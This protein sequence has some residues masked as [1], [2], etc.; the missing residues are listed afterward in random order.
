MAQSDPL[1]M[2]RVISP[3]P[4]TAWH[5]LT[6][7]HYTTSHL[8]PRRSFFELHKGCF[9]PAVPA[10]TGPEP[11]TG[12][13]L[14]HDWG[15][16]RAWQKLDTGN[17]D[18][19]RSQLTVGPFASVVAVSATILTL[20]TRLA[21]QRSLRHPAIHEVNGRGVAFSTPLSEMVLADGPW[22]ATW[23]HARWFY[24]V[25]DTGTVRSSPIAIYYEF[26]FD[27]VGG[28]ATN[29]R[30]IPTGSP[31]LTGFGFDLTVSGGVVAAALSAEFTNGA[32]PAT[33]EPG[34]WQTARV[35]IPDISG[36][37]L[38]PANDAAIAAF[39]VGQQV[40]TGP[41]G[42]DV[43]AAFT[44]FTASP[45]PPGIT[46]EAILSGEYDGAMDP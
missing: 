20:E 45:L 41:L 40:F 37:L 5:S 11:L 27:L 24:D 2:T 46:P 7:V 33:H 42:T 21:P 29:V 17:F 25:G 32:D 3:D 10:L 30:A 31:D 44:T 34:E 6:L 8:D 28:R 1:V 14:R 15:D 36:Y 38:G 12:L 9:D 35:A 19:D 22:M 26:F 39:G 23:L 43:E 18:H 4:C 13:T 16:T